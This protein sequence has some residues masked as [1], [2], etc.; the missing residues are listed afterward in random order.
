MRSFAAACE[1][2]GMTPWDGLNMSP[3][4]IEHCVRS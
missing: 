3:E 1:P 4:K 2:T